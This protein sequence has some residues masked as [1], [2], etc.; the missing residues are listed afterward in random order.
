MRKILTKIVTLVLIVALSVTTFAGCGLISTDTDRDMAQVVATVDIDLYAKNESGE[1]T[2]DAEEIL[3]SEMLSA[4]MSYGYMYVQSYGYTTAATYELIL[5]NLVQNRLII[6]GARRDLAKAYNNYNAQN[7][8]EFLTY[9]KENAL[10]EGSIDSKSNDIANLEKY[11]TAY[12]K[13]QAWYSVR[14]SVNQMIDSYVD[15]EDE[16]AADKEDETY[17]VRGVPTKDTET[18]E[19]EYELKDQ[20]PTDYDYKVADVT[21]KKGVDV[22]KAEYPN[23]YALNKAVFEAYTIDLSTSDRVKALNKAIKDLKNS[24]L[25]K[26]SESQTV[27]VDADNVLKYSYFQNAIKSQYESLIVTKYEDSLIT[28]VEKKLE[29]NVAIFAQ[30]QAEYNAQ[31]ENY[32]GDRSGYESALDALTKDTFVLCNPYDGYGY[33]LNLLIGF[34]T[35]Q[36]AA[37][38]AAQSEKGATKDSI[39]AKRD[40]LLTKLTVK[41][42][43]ET[44]VYSSYGEYANDAFTFDA[45]YFVSEEGS[46]AY[47]LL[48]TFKGNIYG[49]TS[50]EDED[51]SGVIKTTWAFEN[52]IPEVITFDSFLKTYVNALLGTTVVPNVLGSVNLTDETRSAFDDL[53]YAYSTDPGSLGSYL[54]YAYSPV[55]A[56]TTYVKEF[57][58]A[59]KE[60]VAAGEGAYKLIATDYGYHLILCT[61][62]V[63]KDADEYADINEFKTALENEDSLASKYREVK[64]NSIVSTEVGKIADTL[65]NDYYADENIVTYNHKAYKDLIPE[66][67]EDEHEGHNH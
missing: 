55:N 27:R 4:F 16:D 65:I 35:E 18:A 21:L 2:V 25:I 64:L 56:S 28:D 9:F 66:E 6:Q 40:E 12:E 13:A 8:S 49:A 1:D 5:E 29:D 10:A 17:E 31:K 38:S 44:W 11:L 59:S 26:S 20:T 57:A 53:I 45:E 24:G 63:A 30:Y 62:V 52:V 7:A 34:S 19:Y 39:A 15:A 22:L 43:R 67:S 60:V 54:G 50:S 51:D 23:A 32:N 58:D 42:Q 37:L 47:E 41:D 46:A 61:K 36:S 48:K 33:V 14:A 3:K